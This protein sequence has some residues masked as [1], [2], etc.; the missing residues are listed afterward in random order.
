MAKK[1]NGLD[2]DVRRLASK[3]F[4][5]LDSPR[6]LTAAMLL[7]YGEWD[8]LMQLSV[9]PSHY[10]D[11]PWGAE[12]LLRDRQASDFLRK[13]PGLPAG[14][15]TREAAFRGWLACEKQCLHTN[16][17]LNK[18]IG[19]DI[20]FD[21]PAD[22]R[23]MDFIKRVKRL[24][25]MV[26]G[27]VPSQ[28]FSPR[29][30]S[31]AV[32]ESPSYAAKGTLTV[33]HKLTYTVAYT[34][35]AEAIFKFHYQ[36][37]SWDR[38]SKYPDGYYRYEPFAYTRGNRWE[39]VSKTSLTDRPIGVEPGGNVWCQ[40]GVGGYIRRRLRLTWGLLLEEG[41][42]EKLHARLAWIGAKFGTYAT[43]DLS[44]AS[45]TIARLLVKLLLPAEWYDLLAS[46]RSPLT[47]VKGFSEG[48]ETSTDE[49]G[50]KP[51]RDGWYL[52]E[53]FSSMGNG[54]TFELETLIFAAI[55][56]V[57]CGE[58]DWDVTVYGDDIIVPTQHSQSV[59]SA[60]KWFGFTP[61]KRKTFTSGVFRESC[62][63]DYF[64]TKA[65]RP[66]TL[67]IIPYEPQ[68]WISVA[69]GLRRASRNLDLPGGG[70]GCFSSAWFYAVDRLPTAPVPIRT[71]RGPE[72]LGD[73]CLHDRKAVW[74]TR[75]CP[76]T[77]VQQVRCYT[78]VG[79]TYDLARFR[80]DVV[81]ASA[82]IGVSSD[83][84]SPR[85]A[86]VGMKPTWIDLP[87]YGRPLWE[88]GKPRRYRGGPRPSL[89]G[90]G[91]GRWDYD[92][93]VQIPRVAS[94]SS[95]PATGTLKRRAPD[96]IVINT[97]NKHRNS[98]KSPVS[99]R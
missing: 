40:L 77:G 97:R 55:A 53:K 49:D 54:F 86:V 90:R 88:L 39:S 12:Q 93:E 14:V 42:S 31:G 4:E 91:K 9:D 89:E 7:K 58:D 5:A 66:Y 70:L 29:F 57:A 36:D 33:S 23:I 82:L 80:P 67:E 69:N 87:G 2:A 81:L 8:Q 11:S 3:L 52:L 96:Q 30:G 18:F 21:D 27:S 48:D 41:L 35:C 16:L 45:D 73:I 62:G 32:F 59:I 38:A 47:R 17:R 10:P 15:D 79:M 60:L 63:S 76:D 61:N 50:M 56:K 43:I 37:T 24:I 64:G 98:V 84:P 19:P 6:S 68:H 46:L 95:F 25:K 92:M 71:Y 13:Y 26:L 94:A 74:H 83:G 1:K 78:P 22:A 34:R 85:G 99:A 65:V 72:E 75:E 28:G 44:S 20:V 51:I